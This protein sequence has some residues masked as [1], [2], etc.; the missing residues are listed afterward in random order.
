MRVWDPWKRVDQSSGTIVGNLE[1]AESH[2]GSAPS[3]DAESVLVTEVS[4]QVLE[5]ARWGRWS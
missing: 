5:S 2:F 1:D 4:V 3:L